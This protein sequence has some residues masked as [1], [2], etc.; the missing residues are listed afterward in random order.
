M[1]TVRRPKGSYSRP[2]TDFFIER[3]MVGGF[4]HVPAT[5]NSSIA[6]LYNNATDG[7][8]LHVYK[9]W[10]QND[11][12]GG[13]WITRQPGT[14]GGTSVPTYPVVTGYPTRP[15]LFSYADA[16]AVN[17]LQPG[18]FTMPAFI[19]GNNEAGSQ[20]AFYAPGPICVLQPGT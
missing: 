4:F 2:T 13:Y 10:T 15:G 6:E 17:W 3:C 14:I 8:S 9:I 7:S 12:G 1:A 5:G 11:A 19:G 18:G 20:D 16:A